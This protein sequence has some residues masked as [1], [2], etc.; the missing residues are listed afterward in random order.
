MTS[1]SSALR[2]TPAV[3]SD[4]RPLL[5]FF[6][7][8]SVESR[9]DRFHGSLRRFPHP[10]LHAVTCGDGGVI[11]RVARDYR[12][13]PAGGCIAAFGTASPLVGTNEVEVAVWVD[14]AYQRRGLATRLLTGVLE[15]AARDGYPAFVAYLE[16]GNAAAIALARGLARRLGLP[17]PTGTELRGQLSALSV[18]STPR[19]RRTHV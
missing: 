10:Y 3:A 16:P 2:V 13:D 1:S 18:P 7:R 4:I 5:A 8:N 6:R 12:T 11:A 17:P 9:R 15:Q 19:P 14:D